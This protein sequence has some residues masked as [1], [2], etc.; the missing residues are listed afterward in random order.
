MPQYQSLPAIYDALMAG[1]PHTA[2]LARMERAVREREKQPQSV[3]DVA[4]G[5]GTLSELL[6]RRGYRPVVGFD[7]APEM[8]QIARMKS[9][10][11]H[12]EI[13]YSVADLAELDLGGRQFDWLVSVFDSLNYITD[14]VRLREGLRRLFAHAKPG[15]VLTFDMNGIYA[16]RYGLFTQHEKNGPIEHDWKSHWDEDEKL[17]RVEMDFWVTDPHTSTRRYFHETHLQRAYA[18]NEIKEW[19]TEAGWE[20]IEV[21]GNYG[22]RAPNSRSDRWLFVCEKPE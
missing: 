8:V 18:I 10:A 15:G 9:E 1:V 13:A 6:Y 22:D 19:L 4:C 7:I 20:Q 14:P 12:Y 3:L 11:R 17:C 5:T 21:F 2:W 16:L